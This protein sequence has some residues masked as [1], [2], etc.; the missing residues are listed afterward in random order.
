MVNGTR[1]H[2][3]T[4]KYKNDNIV[5]L[6]YLL[7]NSIAYARSHDHRTRKCPMM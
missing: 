1:S 2:F 3:T 4:K 6:V 7:E 5:I